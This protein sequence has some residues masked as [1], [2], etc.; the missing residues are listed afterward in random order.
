MRT[1]VPGGLVVVAIDASERR[2][3]EAR[4]GHGEHPEVVLGAAG[5]A[6]RVAVLRDDA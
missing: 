4:L 6:H 5:W 1:N 2:V 3:V